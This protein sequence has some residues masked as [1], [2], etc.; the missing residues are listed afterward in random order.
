MNADAARTFADWLVSDEGQDGDR[1]IT[2]SSDSNSSFSQRA[3]E[4]HRLIGG[5]DPEPLRR[6]RARMSEQPRSRPIT[7][8]SRSVELRRNSCVLKERKISDLAGLRRRVPCRGGAHRQASLSVPPRSRALIERA[9]SGSAGGGVRS[10]HSSVR[11]SFSGS[12]DPLLAWGIRQSRLRAC[13]PPFDGSLDGL[14]RFVRGEGGGAG[15][16]I[17]DAK[18]GRTGT[19]PA[20]P[21]GSRRGQN[22]RANRPSPPGGA[23]SSSGPAG[24]AP[25]S[26][27]DLRLPQ[28][29][30]TRQPGVG[31]RS[32]VWDLGAPRTGS[33]SPYLDFPAEIPSRKTTRGGARGGRAGGAAAAGGGAGGGAG[34]GGGGG[35]GGGGA[36]GGGGGGGGGGGRAGGGGGG[37]GRP[38]GGRRR[39]GGGGGG[40]GGG[41]VEMFSGGEADVAFGLE[42]LR[43]DLMGSALRPHHPVEAPS[44]SSS[45]AR[46]GFRRRMCV[47]LVDFCASGRLSEAGRWTYGGYDCG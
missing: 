24:A 44:R 41:A 5:G 14:D 19:F 15:L 16:H 25:S 34:A 8:I 38:G 39:A 4:L 1:G 9:E 23:A 28:G 27:S 32:P 18:F 6:Q 2:R 11:R 20:G 12:H 10:R 40:G 31:H 36:R 13:G 43:S 46:P 7:I 30:C 47:T 42:A 21:P 45:T 29:S 17:H 33:T 22:A 3:D 26:L 35:G 37:G